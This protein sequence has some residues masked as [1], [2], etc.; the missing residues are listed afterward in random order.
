MAER[1]FH[2]ARLPGFATMAVVVFIALY[3]PI[4]TL[5]AYSFNA[6]N[7]VAV[8]GGFSLDWYAPLAAR[9]LR[10]AHHGGGD[11]LKRQVAAKVR[12]AR[13]GA[14]GQQQCADGGRQ[15]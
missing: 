7:S 3:L 5:V 11:G 8:W 1:S 6:S 10:T 4:F 2:V 13:A 15:R 9:Q 14:R 12:L